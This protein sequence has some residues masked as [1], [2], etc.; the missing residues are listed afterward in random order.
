MNIATHALLWS[1]KQNS[2]HVESVETM[3]SLNRNRYRGLP[4]Y[5]P[6][7]IGTRHECQDAADACRQTMAERQFYGTDATQI[8]GA[9]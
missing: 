9:S 4:D 1:K 8:G 7:H 2:L 6:I 3:L 5:I